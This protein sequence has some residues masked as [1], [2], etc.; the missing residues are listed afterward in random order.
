MLLR[1][2]IGKDNQTP[3][4]MS[5]EGGREGK[6]GV[7]I[8][9]VVKTGV[10]EVRYIARQTHLLVISPGTSS[11]LILGVNAQV[12]TTE[13]VEKTTTTE[14]GGGTMADS[15]TNKTQII[16]KGLA[17]STRASLTLRVLMLVSRRKI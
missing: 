9:V 10:T 8:I 7:A 1:Q 11:D 4:D 5:R 14:V 15:N 16:L 2:P 13:A 3:R 12:V 6:E 17:S